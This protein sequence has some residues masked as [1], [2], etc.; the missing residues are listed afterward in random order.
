MYCGKHG[1]LVDTC[2]PKRKDL[3]LGIDSINNAIRQKAN[4]R[5]SGKLI[6]L[7]TLTQD[8]AST[9]LNRKMRKAL[10]G[11]VSDPS[12]SD[13]VNDKNAD[14]RVEMNPASAPAVYADKG[15]YFSEPT[16]KDAP[17]SPPP[18]FS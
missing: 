15:G 8:D 16:R 5:M 4:D 13:A 14:P 10:S 18:Y 7:D 12:P 9:N 17:R 1:H 6:A 3:Q 11:T 2:I